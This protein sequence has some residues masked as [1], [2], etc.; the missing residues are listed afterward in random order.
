MEDPIMLINLRWKVQTT[1]RKNYEVARAAGLSE[2]RFSRALAGRADLTAGEQDRI[3]KALGVEDRTWLF[4]KFST[5]PRSYNCDE[6]VA[7][8]ESVAR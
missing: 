2:S 8:M 4:K 5:V 6:P 1:G 3:A 7:A